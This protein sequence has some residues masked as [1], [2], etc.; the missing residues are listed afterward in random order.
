[1]LALYKELF[2]LKKASLEKKEEL[3]LQKSPTK[4]ATLFFH[5]AFIEKKPLLKFASSI[6]DCT[7]YF[8]V[9]TEESETSTLAFLASLLTRTCI[10]NLKSL[11]VAN[12]LLAVKSKFSTIRA[13]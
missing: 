13:I 8:S 1:M 4:T 10:S 2:E 11:L 9:S 12:G 5:S 6:T 7:K 3:Y